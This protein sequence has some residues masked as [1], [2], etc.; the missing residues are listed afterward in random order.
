M[1]ERIIAALRQNG[2]IANRD[3]ARD[4]GVNEATVRTRLRRLED[5]DMLRVVA[6]RDL[7]AMGFEYLAPVGVQVKGRSAAA[8]GEDLARIERVITVNVAIG[9]HDLEIQVVA[10][11]LS[12]MQELL[13]EV[14]AKVDGVARLFPSLALKV[15]KYNPEWA[16]L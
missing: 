5:A 6:M 8:V 4:L 14:I 10:T 15:L 2:R 12:E 13:T 11:S 16:P 1:D 7:S 9:T 3:L